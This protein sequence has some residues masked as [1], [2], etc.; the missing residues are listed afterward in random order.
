MDKISPRAEALAIT[1][2]RLIAVG[3]KEDVAGYKARHTR[4]IDA[5]G[6]TVLPGII[7]SHIHIFPGSVELD[8]L[9]V[10]GVEGIDALACAVR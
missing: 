5:Q 7:E 4:I 8:S 2:N 3:K 9:M 10:T 1:G 6:K